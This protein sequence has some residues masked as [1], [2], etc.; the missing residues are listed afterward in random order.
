MN[1]KRSRLAALA[2][3]GVILLPLPPGWADARSSNN[4]VR[5]NVTALEHARQLIGQGRFVS[6]HKGLWKTD[7][8]SIDKENEFIRLYG[9]AEYAKWH[10]GIDERYATNSKARYKFP[11]GDFESIHRC[12]LLAVKSRAREYRRA[13]IENAA[14][15]L[16][17]MIDSRNPRSQKSID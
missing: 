13:D 14:A 3:V 9:F 15:D 5:L 10:L 12:G 8:P 2:L 7:Q 6:D 11:Y 17:G 1:P 4:T 16:L